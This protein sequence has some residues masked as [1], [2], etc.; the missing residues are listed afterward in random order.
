LHD[1]LEEKAK[2]KMQEI[3]EQARREKEKESIFY[4]AKRDLYDPD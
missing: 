4:E 3:E 1:Q 2:R